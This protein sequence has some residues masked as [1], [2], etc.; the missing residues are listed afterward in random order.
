MGHR[1][2]VMLENLAKYK[3]SSEKV[4]VKENTKKVA[5]SAEQ[6]FVIMEIFNLVSSSWCME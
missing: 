3:L 2:I 4:E 5:R 1:L 6:F